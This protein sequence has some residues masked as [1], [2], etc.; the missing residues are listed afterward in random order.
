MRPFGCTFTWASSPAAPVAP[1]CSLP[2]TT[3][4]TPTVL[5]TSTTSRSS[6]PLPAPATRSAQAAAARSEAS[7]IGSLEARAWSNFCSGMSFQLSHLLLALGL[8]AQDEQRL[9][10][11]GPDEAPAARDH[12]AH[13]V[14]L[15][16]AAGLAQ[17][18]LGALDRLELLVFREVLADLRRA[19]RL[20]NAVQH[21]R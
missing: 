9:R 1:S 13:A 7:V 18:L 10:V 8:P 2:E 17:L 11:G 12:H 3:K 19:E 20:G 15:D 4:P 5:P 21:A 14:D 16:G 6:A